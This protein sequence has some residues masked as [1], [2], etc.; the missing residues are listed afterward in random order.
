MAINNKRAIRIFTFVT[1]ARG[2]SKNFDVGS[3]DVAVVAHRLGNLH[4]WH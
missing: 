1:S 3:A 2:P 4:G